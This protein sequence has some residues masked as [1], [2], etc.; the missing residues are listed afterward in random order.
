MHLL[1]EFRINQYWLARSQHVAAEADAD[2]AWLGAGIQLINPK[3]KVHYF[4]DV[5]VKRD[6]AVLSIEIFGDRIMGKPE[7]L[8]QIGGG[9]CAVNNLG[10][11]F[12]FRLHSLTLAK[13]HVDRKDADCLLISDDRHAID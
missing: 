9:N 10:D 4:R 6:K 12:S 7:K 13:V 2:L 8:I 5:I 3:R 11:D 1:G